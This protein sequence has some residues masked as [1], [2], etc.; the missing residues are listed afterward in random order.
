M[1]CFFQSYGGIKNPVF[2]VMHY[3]LSGGYTL[4]MY[5]SSVF[6]EKT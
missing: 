6:H 1:G 5:F 3:P 4:S 2:G